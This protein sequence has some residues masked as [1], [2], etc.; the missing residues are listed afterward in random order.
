[1]EQKKNIMLLPDTISFSLPN[2]YVEKN[3]NDDIDINYRPSREITLT[4]NKV[5]VKFSISKI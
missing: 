3:F 1:M 5:N 4:Y 2:A